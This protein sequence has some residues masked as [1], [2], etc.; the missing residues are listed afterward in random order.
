MAF[1][2]DGFIVITAV[3]R[4]VVDYCYRMTVVKALAMAGLITI[5]WVKVMSMRK[6][7]LFLYG[8]I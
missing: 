4:A 1:D 7:C 8:Y 5:G 2:G 3:T 6:V